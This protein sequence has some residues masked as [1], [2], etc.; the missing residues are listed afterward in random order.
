MKFF[1]PADFVKSDQQTPEMRIRGFAS[2]PDADRDNETVLQEGLDITDF[3]EHGF[4]NLD[5]DNNII[6]G[7]PDKENTH[8]TKDGLYVEGTLLDTPRA[9]DIWESAVALQKSNAPRRLGFSIEGRVLS[10]DKQGQIL[11]AKV[12]NV[13]ITATPVNPNATWNAIIK[14]MSNCIST[15]T[16]NAL[17]PESLDGIKTFTNK[18][19]SEDESAI[20][21]LQGLQDKLNKSSDV[22]DVKT[23]LMLFK[24]LYGSELDYKLNEVLAEIDK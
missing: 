22:E 3:V 8:I 6:L 2:T 15:Q 24:G 9:R 10:R 14:S 12:T 4:F 7:Y 16:A 19:E 20:Q 17:I 5:H 11:K 13:A 1:V 23:Y 18:L 21:V